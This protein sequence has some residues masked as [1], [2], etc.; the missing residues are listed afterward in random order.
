[1]HVKCNKYHSSNILYNN[2]LIVANA[3]QSLSKDA[4]LYI[5]LQLATAILHHGC[6]GVAKMLPVS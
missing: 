3:S 4:L 2:I 5:H 1:M 6:H